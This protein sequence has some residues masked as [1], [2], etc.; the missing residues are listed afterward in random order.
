MSY[1]AAT[2]L[3]NHPG[4]LQHLLTFYEQELQFLE[5]LLSEVVN[6]NTSHEAM[7]EAEHF[8]N[9]FFIQKKNIDELRNRITQNHHLAAEEAKIHAGR[10]DTRIAADN[11][12]IGDEVHQ[13]EKI[14][15]ELRTA[16]KKYLLKW[17]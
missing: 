12:Q 14:I 13:L 6:K 7:A 9:Q 1:T 17:M 4:E 5:K 8:Q 10:V 16:Y 11:Q 3:P 2:H 15:A